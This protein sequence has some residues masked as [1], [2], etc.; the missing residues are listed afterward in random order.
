MAREVKYAKFISILEIVYS[1]FLAVGLATLFREF[2]LSVLYLCY[3]I[4]SL[5]VLTR[6]FFAPS[7]NVEYLI[8]NIYEANI[9]PIYKANYYRIVLLFDIPILFAHAYLFNLMCSNVG[10]KTIINYP[11]FYSFVLLLIINWAWLKL[12]NKRTIKLGNKCSR[13]LDFW[14]NNNITFSILM[15]TVL[16]FGKYYKLIYPKEALML[17][18]CPLSLSFVGNIALMVLAIGNCFRDL[19]RTYRTYL[20]H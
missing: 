7:K 15:I 5:L 20:F 13:Y 18:N 3:T 1:L 6:F 2:N 9:K 17:N 11:F 14:A 19:W 12:I 4:I 10:T 8:N 16:L